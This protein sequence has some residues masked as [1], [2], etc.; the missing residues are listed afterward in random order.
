[1]KKA[2]ILFTFF[3]SS[4]LAYAQQDS[5]S[6]PRLGSPDQAENRGDLDKQTLKTTLDLGFAD[7]Y[8][9]LKDSLQKK[10]GISINFDYTSL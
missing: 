1:M 6:T 5:T 8:F 4:T 7:P 10:T 2:L 9:A 3:S